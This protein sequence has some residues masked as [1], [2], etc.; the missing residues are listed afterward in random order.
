MNKQQARQRIGKLKKVIDYQSQRRT[1]L[2]K[3]A[4][5]RV[6]ARKQLFEKVDPILK[7]YVTT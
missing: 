7:K 1:S 3:I 5:L 4:K 6:E 2:D